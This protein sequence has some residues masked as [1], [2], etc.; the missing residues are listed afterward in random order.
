MTQIRWII[1]DSLMFYLRKSNKSACRFSDL[2]SNRD[3]HVD[4]ADPMDYR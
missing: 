2:R 1:A 3:K 4:D